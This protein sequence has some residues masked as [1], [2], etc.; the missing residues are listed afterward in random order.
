M[1]S[2]TLG[3]IVDDRGTLRVRSYP[4]NGSLV[5]AG[6]TAGLHY[7]RILG[8]EAPRSKPGLSSK[9][10]HSDFSIDVSKA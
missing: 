6:G 10:R 2:A 5:F 8:V 9:R 3:E 1:D 4:M 7:G